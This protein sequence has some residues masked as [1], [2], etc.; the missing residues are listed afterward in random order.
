MNRH[1]R[2]ALASATLLVLSACNP[3]SQPPGGTSGGTAAPGSSAPP[4]SDAPSAEPSLS[5]STPPAATPSAAPA[6]V[7]TAAATAPPAQA[8]AGLEAWT[9]ANPVL[10]DEARLQT[11][12]LLS[13]AAPAAAASRRVLQ[14]D[15]ELTEAGVAVA[16]TPAGRTAARAR[17]TA[18]REAA[19]ARLAEQATFGAAIAAAFGKATVRSRPGGGSIR[20]IELTMAGRGA[21][22]TARLIRAV[23]AQGDLVYAWQQAKSA[24][25][26]IVVTRTRTLR[27]DGSVAVKYSHG[28]QGARGTVLKSAWTRTVSPDGTA[29]GAGIVQMEPPTG[30]TA[31]TLLVSLKGTD[32]APLLIVKDP[33]T[34]LELEVAHALGAASTATLIRLDAG[35]QRVALDLGATP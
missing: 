13:D 2:L 12:D 28:D 32:L 26:S 22:W 34:K 14:A 19:K 7:A 6:A 29:T 3:G 35:N 31:K 15:A 23:D 8:A 1:A 33:A 17:R 4:A 25:N 30:T 20:L 27:E 18:V 24:D 21:D 11:A 9:G 10:V 5:V 16:L